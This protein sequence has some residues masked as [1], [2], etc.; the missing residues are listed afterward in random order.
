MSK[1]IAKFSFGNLSFVAALLAA[2]ALCMPR[3][4]AAPQEPVAKKVEVAELAGA[5][6]IQ[7][8][9]ATL[10]S[11]NGMTFFKIRRLPIKE[12]LISD[13]SKNLGLIVKPSEVK[14][15]QI[16]TEKEGASRLHVDQAT[17]H[18]TLHP[19]WAQVAQSKPQLVA[20]EKAFQMADEFIRKN[21]LL[22]K[23]VSATSPQHL[24]TL[25]RAE[26]TEGKSAV[27]TDIGQTVIFQ[28]KIA[29]KPVVGSGSVVTVDLGYEG[30]VVGFRRAWNALAEAGVKP[31]FKTDQEIYAEVGNQVKS[32]VRGEGTAKVAKLHLIYY[33]SDKE[34]VQPAYFFSIQ[35]DAPGVKGKSFL[36]GVVAAAKNSPE[37]IVL[38]PA[39]KEFPAE[40]KAALNVTAPE[41]SGAA[42]DPSVGRYV[43][44]QDSNDWVDDANEFRQ[45]LIDGHP[46]SFPAIT[47]GDYY[48]DQPYM[49]TTSEDSFVDR[50]NITLMEGHGNTWLFTTRS[51]CCDVVNLNSSS[52]PG[53]GDRAG[54]TMRFLVLKGC[55]IIPGP[56]DRS[57]WADPWWRIFKGL[58]QA[59]GFRTEMYIDDDISYGFAKNIASNYRV[60][61]SWFAATN[62]SS[63]YQWERFWGSWGDQI[64]GYGTVVMI[65]GHEG[66]GIYSTGAA[67]AA[68]SAGLTIWY[69]H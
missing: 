33:G 12:S 21:E 26:V 38:P 30:Q 50:W 56:P 42:G 7:I 17:G 31:Q 24:V 23:D 59:V 4:E 49:W 64:Y 35:I 54:D 2:L 28:R 65:P 1:R 29:E 19:N 52:Q 34:F 10:E 61:D 55:S 69:Q 39:P 25:S 67:P 57:N 66:D 60:L 58:R 6:K 40:G 41:S 5:P 27:I 37:A 68:S 43:V 8:E 15:Q 51:N 63:S 9:R 20:K 46:G 45:G 22:E 47:F 53:Y 13:Y 62:G 3:L 44:R 48:W 16:L 32:R 14:S 11:P 36:T 18:M